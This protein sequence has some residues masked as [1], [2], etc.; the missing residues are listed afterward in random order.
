MKEKQ[1][2]LLVAATVAVLNFNPNLRAGQPSRSGAA[3]QNRAFLT[4]PRTLEEFPAFARAPFP[5]SEV[6]PQTMRVWNRAFA[7]SPRALE[8]F[9][10]LSRVAPS[11]APSDELAALPRNRA[12][13]A[14]PRTLEEFPALSRGGLKMAGSVANGATPSLAGVGK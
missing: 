7:A 1:A 14:A 10:E 6:R 11:R 5:G 12:F 2:L 9:P 8:E 13:L 3:S 4:A